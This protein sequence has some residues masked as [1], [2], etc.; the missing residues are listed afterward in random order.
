REPPGDT[1][2]REISPRQDDRL[3][4]HIRARISLPRLKLFVEIPFELIEVVERALGECQPGY[5]AKRMLACGE[6]AQPECDFKT[7]ADPIALERILVPGE[8]APRTHY[9][10]G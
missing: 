10:V 8:I 1:V 2:V 9:D 6:V 5:V 3:L 7:F 4:G